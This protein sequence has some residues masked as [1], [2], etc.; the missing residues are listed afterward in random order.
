M[1][2]HTNYTNPC[3]ITITKKHQKNYDY[4]YYVLKYIDDGYEYYCS[5]EEL[6]AEL[7]EHMDNMRSE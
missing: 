7:S 3:R 1:A 4:D 2:K 6:L 5:Q